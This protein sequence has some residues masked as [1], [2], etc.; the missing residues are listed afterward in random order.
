MS[1]ALVA[2][3]RRIALCFSKIH[4][5]VLLFAVT[6]TIAAT[7]TSDYIHPPANV[8]T[9]PLYRH[10]QQD[11]PLSHNAHIWGW[12]SLLMLPLLLTQSTCTSPL[13]FLAH[14]MMT[15]V[16]V[17][18]AVTIQELTA[19]NANVGD[20]FGMNGVSFDGTRALIGA[21][22][23][24]CTDQPHLGC[25]A[26]YIF[27]LV[28]LSWVQTAMLRPADIATWTDGG[29][30][31]SSTDLYNNL[32]IIGAPG[33]LLSGRAYIFEYIANSWVQK[34]ELSLADDG[35]PT[36]NGYF[37]AGVAIWDKFAIAGGGSIHY[38]SYAFVYELVGNSWSFKQ[39]LIGF[40]GFGSIDMG[41]AAAM[42][43]N[44]AVVGATNYVGEGSGFV[45]RYDGS[46]WLEDTR[47]GDGGGGADSFGRA[48]GIDPSG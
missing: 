25:G 14:M 29:N 39:Q 13:L 15:R 41:C 9:A 36:D 47:L 22:M 46:D 45:Y 21:A 44:V 12:N 48:I 5:I 20:L 31:G 38:G 26:A 2:A 17:T 43:N 32:A 6:C 10:T 19:S 33:H 40:G 23:H 18:H 35:L 28:G 3:L 42:T 1:Y 24:D 16:H 7:S 8:L 4:S 11:N 27:E 34:A 30:F 37:G